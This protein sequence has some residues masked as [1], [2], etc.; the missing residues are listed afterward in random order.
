MYNLKEPASEDG[1]TR[2]TEDAD[3]VKELIDI[4]LPDCTEQDVSSVRRLGAKKQE[5]GDSIQTKTITS[6][7]QFCPI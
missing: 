5:E 6:N 2:K 1:P 3:K 7:I 4:I